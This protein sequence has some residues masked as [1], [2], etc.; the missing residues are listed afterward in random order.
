MGDEVID[1]AGARSIVAGLHVK[2]LVV[3]VDGFRLVLQFETFGKSEQSG[4]VFGLLIEGATKFEFGGASLP[5]FQQGPGDVEIGFA[6]IG[7]EGEE[8][9]EFRGGADG[10]AGTLECDSQDVMGM[11]ESGAKIDSFA[12]RGDGVFGRGLQQQ[13]AQVEV[14]LEERGIEGDGAFVFRTSFGVAL[15]IACSSRRVGSGRRR[16]RVAGR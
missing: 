2:I 10:I 3:G 1:Q 7:L 14:G 11:A 9:L 15:Q 16:G 8:F 4:G 6:V 12:K 5:V 13:S